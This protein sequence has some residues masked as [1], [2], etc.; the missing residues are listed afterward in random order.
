M[1]LMDND[2]ILLE[3]Q[4]YF[5]KMAMD[6][7]SVLDIVRK[8]GYFKS[9]GKF[10]IY[11]EFYINPCE[12]AAIFISHGLCEFT[13]KYEE[14]IYK[15]FSE[16]YSVFI[17]DYRG[18]G[19]SDRA[20]SDLSKVYTRSF[21]DYVEDAKY[22]IQEIVA[23]ESLTGSIFLFAHSMGGTIGAL[24][25]EEYP[26]LF[27]CAVLS[28][29]MFEINFGRF[30]WQLA[31]VVSY[32]AK[33]FFLGKRY[34]Y[35]QKP[36]DIAYNFKVNN[37]CVSEA[38]YKYILQKRIKDSKYRTSGVTYAWSSAGIA[39]VR[40]LHRNAKK[41]SVP[42]LI[43]QA[44]L[45]TLV[46]PKGQEV[47]ARNVPDAEIIVIKDAKHEIYNAGT[48]ARIEYYKRILEFYNKWL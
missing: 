39:A 22:F 10:N 47:F 28:S 37:T 9:C 34:A 40:K 11:Y 26:R 17:M 5:T 7:S 23:K 45:D 6:V 42:V 38:R 29:P 14:V 35:G 4:E 21:M 8:K 44:G 1:F 32:M 27:K 16:G 15:F 41:A 30:P 3:G 20:V 31:S 24:L 46:K 12:K 13:S 18:H 48:S 36:F 19:Y 2:I 43:F 33:F 25:L